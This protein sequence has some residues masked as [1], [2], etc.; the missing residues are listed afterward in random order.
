MVNFE[1]TSP[2]RRAPNRLLLS[3]IPNELYL[4]IFGFLEPSLETSPSESNATLSNLAK[5]CRF[6]CVYAISRMYRSLDLSGEL[7]EGATS[8]GHNALCGL[9][10]KGETYASSG[11]PLD[12]SMEL[13]LQVASFVEEC[14]FRDWQ[15]SKPE[16]LMPMADAFLARN[17]RAVRRLPKVTK[18]TLINTP[19]TGPLIQMAYKLR[20]TLTT[21]CIHQ[22]PLPQPL[23]QDERARLSKLTLSS[24]EFFSGALTTPFDFPPDT[25]RLQNLVTFK[26]DSAQ[27]REYFFRRPHPMLRCL[28]LDDMQLSEMPLFFH[29]LQNSPALTNLSILN[30]TIL[31]SEDDDPP[32]VQKFADVALPT[33]ETLSIPALL[34]DSCLCPTVRKLSVLGTQSDLCAPGAIAFAAAG[35]HS[36]LPLRTFPSLSRTSITPRQLT[37][38]CLT[39]LHIPQPIYLSIPIHKNLPTLEV[40]VLSWCHLN[41]NWPPRKAIHHQGIIESLSGKGVFPRLRELRL[42]LF[43]G[44]SDE[45]AD[46]MNWDLAKERSLITGHLSMMFPRLM[47]F[48]RTPVFI[49]ERSGDNARWNV[50]IPHQYKKLVNSR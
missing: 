12:D 26:T 20:S 3:P 34:L 35:I 48:T 6:F 1:W 8:N 29:R 22:C 15:S 25:L 44:F 28:E 5:V 41:F 46:Y 49:W 31:R 24:L 18:I 19:L 10:A 36:R 23:S 45:Y 7:D 4:K 43:H 17:A 32:K 42:E 13:A 38:S 16:R 14:T 27:L 37:T 9:L 11:R 39:E 21:L 50:I 47:F 40:L 30:V 2:V 33:L